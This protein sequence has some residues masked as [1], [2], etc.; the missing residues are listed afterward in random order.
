MSDIDQ[1]RA[2]IV[3]ALNLAPLVPP[4]AD[5]AT[6]NVVEDAWGALHELVVAARDRDRL[7]AALREYEN[8]GN[9]DTEDGPPFVWVKDSDPPR[10]ARAA[11]AHTDNT[12]ERNTQ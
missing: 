3:Q 9:W 7:V 2:N 8:P 1:L 10:I 11:L 12:T 5:T 4:Q 6:M